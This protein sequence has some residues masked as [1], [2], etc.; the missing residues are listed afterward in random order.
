MH[1]DLAV[2]DGD[3]FAALRVND[4]LWGG[5]L[6]VYRALPGILRA[7]IVILFRLFARCWQ[8]PV[9]IEQQ[10]PRESRLDIGKETQHENF[11]I[12]ENVA[13]VAEA[14]QPLG[15]NAVATVMRRG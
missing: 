14:C 13:P 2:Q 15:G 6:P 3:D 1:F 12:V 8:Q 10:I 9:T 5:F 4:R 7:L 11:G